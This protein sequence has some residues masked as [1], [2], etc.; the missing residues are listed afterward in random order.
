MFCTCIRCSGI[1]FAGP[2]SSNIRRYTF[3]HTSWW[4]GFMK[5]AVQVGSRIY[6]YI[7]SFFR[8]GSFIQKLTEM[9]TES[10][11][12]PSDLIRLLPFIFPK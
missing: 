8:I 9:D 1:A 4:E 3:K 10:H 5:H 11:R 2:L 12:Q 7:P 6:V